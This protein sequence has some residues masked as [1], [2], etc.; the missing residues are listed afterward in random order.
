MTSQTNDLVENAVAEGGAYEVLRKRLQEQGLRLRELVEAL[1]KERLQEFG[2]SD[3]DILSRI[4]VRTEN[5]CVARD[6]VRVGDF[7]LFGYN[8]FIGL[9]KET[10]VSDVFALY[11]LTETEQGLELSEHTSDGTFLADAKFQSDFN[12][13]YTYYKNA[14]LLQIVVRQGRLLAAFQIGERLEDL[15]VFQWAVNAAGEVESYIDNRGER[16]IQLP[17]RHDFEWT[18]IKREQVIEGL[19]PHINIL[20]TLFVDNIR[21]DLTFKIENNTRTGEGIFSDP[22]EDENQSLDDGQFFYAQVGELILIKVLPYR[23]ESWRYYVFNKRLSKVTRIDAIGQSCVQ[24]PEDHGLMFPGGYYLETGELKHFDEEIDGFRFKRMIR[25]PN[26]E[27]VL[28]VFYEIPQGISGLYSYNLITKSLQNPIVG[29]GYALLNDGRMVVFTADDEPTRIHPMQVWKTPYFSETFAAQETTSQTFLGRIGNKELVRGISDLLSI[30]RLVEQNVASFEHYNSLIKSAMRL[31][32]QYYWLDSKELAEVHGLLKELVA[33]GELVLDEYEKVASI[34]DS[35]RTALEQAAADK[36]KLI[37]SLSPESWSQPGDFVNALDSARKLRGRLMTLRD[38]RYIDLS[39]IDAME[40]ELVETEQE[41]A[42]ETVKFLATPKALDGYY[43]RLDELTEKAEKLETRVELKPLLEEFGSISAGLDLLSELVATLEVE[44]AVQRTRIIDGISEIYAKINQQKAKVQNKAKSL[45][46]KEA[47]AQ[48]AAQFRL[49]EQSLSNALGLADTPDKCD[50]LLSRLLNQL[51]E[52]E[53]QFGEFDEFL[54]DILAKRDEVYDAFDKHKQ[55]LI[56]E[57]QRKTHTLADAAGR[58]LESIGK[59]SQRFQQMDEVNTFFASD[60]LA[61]KVR[62]I[63]KQLRDLGDQIAADDLESRLKSAKEQA[64]RGL[65]DKT[66]IF[67]EG[68]KVIKLGPRHRFSVNTQELDLSILPRD[69]KL[70]IHVTGSDYYQPIDDP[71]LDACRRYWDMTLMSETPDV[72]RSEFLAH[73]FLEH[74]NSPRQTALKDKV[75]QALAAGDGVQPF[76]TEFAGPRYKEGYEKGIHDHDAALILAKV[77]PVISQ[78]QLLRYTGRIRALACLF[79]SARQHDEES[80]AW[81][82]QARAAQIMLDVLNSPQAM[83]QLEDALGRLLWEFVERQRLDFSEVDVAQAAAYLAAELGKDA[84]AFESGKYAMDSYERMKLNLQTSTAWNMLQE[85]MKSLDGDLGARWRLAQSWL[86]AFLQKADQTFEDYHYEAVAILA[87]EQEIPRDKREVDLRFAVSGLLGSHPR[88]KEQT[89]QLALD[90]FMARMTRH[91]EEDIA[92]YERYLK[93]RQQKLEQAR[94]MLRLNELKPRPLTSFVR[95]KLINDHYLKF[96]GDNLAKQMGTV[97]ESKRTDNMG[98]LMMIS[99]PGYGKTT[100]MEYTAS[101]LGLTFVKVNCPSLGHDVVSLDP[102]KAPHSTARQELIKLNFGFELANNVMLYLD[103]IQHT[104]PEFLQKFISLCDGTRRVE[105]VWNGE[106]RTYDLRGKKFCIV[107]AGNPYTESGETF[108]VPDMLANR[109]DIYN[110]GDVLGGMEDAFAMSYIEN[111]MT[112]NPV[113]APLA[114]RDMEDFYRF[115]DAAKGREVAATDMKH[116]YSGA[117]FKEVVDVLGKLMDVQKVVLRVNQE[118]IRSSAQ[119]DA[120]RSEPTFKLQGSYRNMNKLAEKITSV[121]T[122]DELQQLLEDHYQGE[123]QLL[124]QGAEENLLKLAELRGTLTSDQQIRWASI[125]EEFAKNRGLKDMDASQ[126]AVRQLREMTDGLRRL[127]EVV[128]QGNKPALPVE[129]SKDY[130][131]DVVKQLARMVKAMSDLKDAA[132]KVDVAPKVEVVNQPMPGLDKILA[133]LA[134]TIQNS[135]YPL[136]K[137]MDGKLQLDLETHKR[138][139]ELNAKIDSL[140]L[141]LKK[142][143]A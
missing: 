120:Y 73:R 12:E 34:Q 110:L 140:R 86:Q 68:G 70:F 9:K 100:L 133:T 23:E 62:Q 37:Q 15:R 69:D 80:A 138:M 131:A 99:P 123:S 30:C 114:T 92:G 64:V 77:L 28:F 14:K 59:R 97:G 130:S 42:Q 72:Y 17:P 112:S 83:M 89:L 101:R 135:I 5:N 137:T 3:M 38:Y 102:E 74:I 35:S 21:G 33:S 128:G 75:M 6:I 65:R 44:D 82:A 50:E 117:E 13:L 91:V 119:A 16:Y 124:T 142:P 71:E 141:E 125:K 56:E 46:S 93:L 57:R 11:Q 47:T 88:I 7:L 108:K 90:D 115:I 8:V 54:G 27:D 84:L 1:N 121:M 129:A 94:K 49:F 40:A 118:Y 104:H 39:A 81:R 66:D 18:E 136:V 126:Q 32:D 122:G 139:A 52:L 41:L 51:Q 78:A 19:H 143:E 25:S 61:Q 87:A 105:G 26:G 31:F 55:R 2:S 134:D 4:R 127:T 22:V 20:D 67:E 109:A 103:D 132:P 76:V 85:S 53:G 111:A 79:W 10:K 106:T 60:A 36:K 29:H 98:L 96:I 43:E 45:G 113:L 107:M 116:T 48:F 95:N 58:I 24:L 63:V